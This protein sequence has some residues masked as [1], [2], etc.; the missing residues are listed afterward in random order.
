MS[1][2]E[3]AD[4]ENLVRE[5][6]ASEVFCQ[7]LAGDRSRV[8]CITPLQYGDSITVWVGL[9]GDRLHISDYGES[10]VDAVFRTPRDRT[11]MIVEA[12]GLCRPFGVEAE[13]ELLYIRSVN[14]SD[15]GDAVWRLASASAVVARR[16][17]GFRKARKER[18]SEDAFAQEIA[19]ELADRKLT[20]QR[21]V[22]LSG[23]S[24]HQHRATIYVPSVEAILE[25]I[26]TQGHYNQISS[27]YTKF[28]D[29]SR[30]NGYS[31]YSL[32]DDRRGGLSDDLSAILVQ[33]S[34]V[35]QWTRRDEWIERL[36]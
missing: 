26:G 25:P 23:S 36:S 10:F 28:G 27:V 20:V 17:E 18:G 22:R 6:V 16:L 24:G 15:V 21:E 4:V 12:K 31:R 8:G 14:Q 35:I 5:Y 2:L 7:P 29:L 1:V 13:D 9:Y 33:V 34:D 11:D 3:L 32:V 19:H 30:A